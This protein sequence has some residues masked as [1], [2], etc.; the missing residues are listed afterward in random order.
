MCL[1]TP[2]LKPPSRVSPGWLQ[3]AVPAGRAPCRSAAP[4]PPPG[5]AAAVA[6]ASAPRHWLDHMPA[7]SHHTAYTQCIY[8]GSAHGTGD[9]PS[10][11]HLYSCILRLKRGGCFGQGQQVTGLSVLFPA[12]IA[13]CRERATVCCELAHV[14]S[15]GGLPSAPAYVCSALLAYGRRAACRRTPRRSGAVVTPSHAVRVGSC[16]RRAM[17]QSAGWEVPI[18]NPYATSAICNGSRLA[19]APTQRRLALKA[20]P[21]D[22]WPQKELP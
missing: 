3:R 15:E 12:C 21:K 18:Y 7:M 6:P 14:L 5:H 9:A 8:L 2:T 4:G 19:S 13:A 11:A 16:E 10:Q 22:F 20:S 17:A 1:A